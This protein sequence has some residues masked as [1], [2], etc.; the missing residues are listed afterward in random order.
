[1]K[2]ESAIPSSTTNLQTRSRIRDLFYALSQKRNDAMRGL[3]LA[4]TPSVLRPTFTVSKLLALVFAILVHTLSLAVGM[5]GV[6]LIAGYGQGGYA[7][8]PGM[9][10]L[11]LAWLLRPHLGNFPREYVMT[12]AEAPTLYAVV[13]A[14][15]H[16]LDAPPIEGI[17]I[18]GAYNAGLRRVGFRQ[19]QL[20]LLGKPLW[21]VL[22]GQEHVALLAHELAHAVNGDSNRGLVVGSA[23]N[24][25]AAWYYLLRPPS[26]YRRVL[27]RGG[28][29]Y[30]SAVSLGDWIP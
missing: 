8:L 13:D 15:A 9:M 11:A 28:M 4:S 7:I 27:Q 18:A 10:F 12:R 25:L 26:L 1:M 16:T 23:C 22:Q 29:S 21:D 19:R 20:L 30:V 14:I 17:W 5:F 24:A 3:L 2:P 6:Y